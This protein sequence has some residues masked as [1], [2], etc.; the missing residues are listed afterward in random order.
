MINA[1]ERFN[2]AKLARIN[3]VEN[4]HYIVAAL[5]LFLDL[6][7]STKVDIGGDELY[8][9]EC[10]KLLSFGYVDITPITPTLIFL[11]Q[12]IF[13]TSL[14]ALRMI[15][16]LGHAVTVLVT[17]EVARELG[18]SRFART[19]SA[20]CVLCA[21][22][23]LAVG[24]EFLTNSLENPIWILT[25]LVI[26]KVT[27]ENRPRLWLLAGF[28]IGLGFMNKPTFVLLA[29]TLFAFMIVMTPK[30]Q[31][32]WIFGAACVSLA[33][34]LPNLV[35]QMQNDWPTVKFA[36]AVPNRTH[37]K[38]LSFGD[39]VSQLILYFNPISS[40]IW[41]PGIIRLFQR[42]LRRFLAFPLAFIGL[43]I[44]I[45]LKNLKAY[46]L[47]PMLPFFIASGSIF[48]EAFIGFDGQR[49]K[50]MRAI[51]LGAL[52]ISG[53]LLLPTVTPAV[54][55]EKGFEKYIK[56]VSLNLLTKENS[57]E[58]FLPFIE[59]NNLIREGMLQE[60]ATIYRSESQNFLDVAIIANKYQ[61]ASA[62]NLMGGKYGL[63]KSISGN[64]TYFT[65]GTNGH[66]GESIIA[67]DFDEATLRTMFRAVKKAP[68]LPGGVKVF[69]CSQ[70][71][72]PLSVLWPNFQS[73]PN[74]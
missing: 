41:V 21:P 19:L 72:A 59:K 22:A 57:P 74:N 63:P 12:D 45:W 29:C 5:T 16:S 4:P 20:L 30:E 64:V 52:T 36:L 10:S 14:L 56:I 48:L 3:A 11:I 34:A 1:F 60:L 2:L 50:L 24:Q 28:L 40:L 51:S 43:F 18:G 25:C 47:V 66:S 17:G 68:D 42:D 49:A 71:I 54:F 35:W 26:I 67:L 33:V 31:L 73:F 53:L 13:G 27:K 7:I 9:I 23:C 44:L 62:I 70:P 8:F 61:I 58:V 39:Y 65:W 46:Y 38:N 32:P 15:P 55:S 69:T 37:L 6:F